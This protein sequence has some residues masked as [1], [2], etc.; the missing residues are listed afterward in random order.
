MLSQDNLKVALFFLLAVNFIA[1]AFMVG[2]FKEGLTDFLFPL[3][4]GICFIGLGVLHIP[5]KPNKPDKK[6]DE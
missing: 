6:D 2:L 3:S 1:N 5:K 4:V